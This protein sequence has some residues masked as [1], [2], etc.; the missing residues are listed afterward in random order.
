MLKSLEQNVLHAEEVES[1]LRDE[2]SMA[3]ASAAAS[4]Q[5]STYRRQKNMLQANKG[6]VH[7]NTYLN[8]D[9]SDAKPSH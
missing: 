9:N 7:A 3:G 5:L 1:A 4:A 6:N 8:H 2:N